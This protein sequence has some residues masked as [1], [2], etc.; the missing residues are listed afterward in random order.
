ML[1]EVLAAQLSTHS[2]YHSVYTLHTLHLPYTHSTHTLYTPYSH[3]THTLLTC[4]YTLYTPYTHPI[5]T[6]HTPGTQSAH[7]LYRHPT[8]TLYICSHPTHSLHM[9]ARPPHTLCTSC[10]C[11][12]ALET[13]TYPTHG[14]HILQMYAALQLTRAGSND[15]KT[16]TSGATGQVYFVCLSMTAALQA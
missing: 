16:S 13:D 7:T 2:L 5:H 11:V 6:L 10:I 12:F 4:V 14:L 1:V 8:H 3:S 15:C 9:F